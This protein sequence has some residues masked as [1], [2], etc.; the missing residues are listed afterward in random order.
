MVGAPVWRVTG[1]R[2][3]CDRGSTMAISNQAKGANAK[4]AAA[5]L[6]MAKRAK[7]ARFIK[8][9]KK[10]ILM[11]VCGF[12]LIVGLCVFTPMGP[13]YYRSMLDERRMDRPGVVSP[14]AIKDLY[15]LGV[16]YAYSFRGS[17]A[18]ECFDEIGRLYFG[19]KITAYPRDVPGN[20][21][22]R[23]LA[24]VQKKKGLSQGPP[25]EIDGSDI[26][27]VAYAVWRTGE[28]IQH[29]RA[30]QDTYVIYRDLYM[31]EFA[32]KHTYP[33]EPEVTAL[34]KAWNDRFRGIR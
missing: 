29:N 6:R 9:N 18:L 27:Y 8:E 21:E 20:I 11:I 7:R 19:F 3:A 14:G 1:E 2:S 12:L 10:R 24:E 25:F 4:A 22:K 23:R 13:G 26:P 32:D 17:L 15:G 30:K 31:E 33:L 28:I 34:V 5:R 16:F